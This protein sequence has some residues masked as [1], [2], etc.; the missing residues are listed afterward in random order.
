M[1]LTT[2]PGFEAATAK[3]LRQIRAEG[4][5]AAFAACL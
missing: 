4:A 3:T 1:D 5:L 2:I